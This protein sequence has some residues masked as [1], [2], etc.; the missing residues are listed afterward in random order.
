MVNYIYHFL[1]RRAYVMKARVQSLQFYISGAFTPEQA[2]LFLK[3]LA[4]N[5]LRATPCRTSKNLA[6]HLEDIESKRRAG[7]KLPY[8]FWER[9]FEWRF[10][11]P[12]D[13]L[14]IRKEYRYSRGVK[15]ACL[16]IKLAS[17]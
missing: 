16:T 14:N 12:C 15:E 3:T 5:E 1:E 9:F 11:L 2:N 10:R 7:M 8:S 13:S 17:S 6:P 4:Q